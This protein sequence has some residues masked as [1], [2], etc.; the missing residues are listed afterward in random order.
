MKLLL[1][2]GPGGKAHLPG[3]KFRKDVY[4]QK[5]IQREYDEQGINGEKAKDWIHPSSVHIAKE[6]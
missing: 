2:L 4:G 5:D 6:N 1:L 3:Y